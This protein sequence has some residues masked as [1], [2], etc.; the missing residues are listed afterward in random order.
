[1]NGATG[2]TDTLGSVLNLP[3]TSQ[4][5]GANASAGEVFSGNFYDVLVYSTALSTTQRQDVE[6]YLAWKW[7]IQATLPANH[8]YRNSA[9]A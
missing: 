2:S 5:I 1:L 6:G 7:G 4:I 9:P 8:P 3:T